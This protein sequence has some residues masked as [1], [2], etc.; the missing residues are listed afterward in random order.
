MLNI[1][2]GMQNV[3]IYQSYLSTLLTEGLLLKA[4]LNGGFVFDM[5]L[6]QFSVRYPPT[7]I[8]T[9]HAQVFFKNTLVGAN[10]FSALYLENAGS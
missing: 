7:A 4:R 2:Q 1:R 5:R 6:S 10:A 8:F 3:D 9:L